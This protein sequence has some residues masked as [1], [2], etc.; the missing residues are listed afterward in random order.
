MFSVK[1]VTSIQWPDLLGMR[2]WAAWRGRG[3]EWTVVVFFL[4]HRPIELS[5][6]IHAEVESSVHPSDADQTHCQTD[7]LQD[8]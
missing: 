7:E 8:T 5:F 3:C 4:T 2:P 6:L 1:Q